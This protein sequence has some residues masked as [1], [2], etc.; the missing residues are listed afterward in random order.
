MAG[1]FFLGAVISF[2]VLRDLK[3]LSVISAG[4]SCQRNCVY[5]F[6]ED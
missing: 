3:A 6:V 1:D 2:Y 5:L 4:L